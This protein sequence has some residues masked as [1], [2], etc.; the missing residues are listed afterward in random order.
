M[1]FHGI[2]FVSVLFCLMLS[3]QIGARLVSISPMHITYLKTSDH[4]IIF[5]LSAGISCYPR[6]LYSALCT[7]SI[8][9][10]EGFV[11]E[12]TLLWLLHTYFC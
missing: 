10:D 8:S 6:P 5:W 9:L 1:A 2:I 12:Y 3:I 4:C 7:L 11:K